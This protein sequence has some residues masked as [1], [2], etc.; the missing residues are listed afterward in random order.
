MVTNIFPNNLI[1]QLKDRLLSLETMHA[2]RSA[3]IGRGSQ[4]VQN[5][6][7]RSDEILWLGQSDPVEAEFLNWMEQ[8]RVGLNRRLFLGLFDF[9][10]H[11]AIYNE[12]AYYRRHVDAFLG[13]RNRVVTTVFYLNDDWKPEDGGELLMFADCGI[14]GSDADNPIDVISPVAGKMVIFMSDRYPHEVLPARRKRYSIA[15][16]FRLN[17]SDSR[18]AAPPR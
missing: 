4:H 2:L 12:G 3:G 15:G 10:C 18:R 16:W 5:S 9:E 11:F 8:L 17:D 6:N 13:Q 7:V 14:A 1:G